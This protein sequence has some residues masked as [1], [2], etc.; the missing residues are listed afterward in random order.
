MEWLASL[1]VA[2]INEWGCTVLN[3]S[4]LN[5]EIMSAWLA[6]RLERLQQMSKQL[7][8]GDLIMRLKTFDPML[9]VAITRLGLRPNGFSSYRG[10]YDHLAL[11][12]TAE[13]GPPVLSSD[14][15]AQAYHA[16]GTAFEGYKGGSYFMKPGTPLWLSNVGEVSDMAIIGL[17]K[18]DKRLFIKFK[19]VS[20]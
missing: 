20:E 10:Y 3:A 16:N 18:D 6:R 19:K 8:L 14:L 4:E 13:R 5:R 2:T 1:Y 15:L 17:Y 12:W 11:A 9:E 7:T